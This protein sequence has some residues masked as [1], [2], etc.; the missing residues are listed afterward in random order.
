ML[1]LRL[2]QA[3]Y[4]PLLFVTCIIGIGAV[5]VYVFKQPV[6]EDVN[7]N[8]TKQA[9]D[10][11][12]TT[13]ESTVSAAEEKDQINK[14]VLKKVVASATPS[15]KPVVSLSP[16]VSPT[17]SFTSSFATITL[18][19]RADSESPNASGKVVVELYDIGSA[20]DPRAKLASFRIQGNVSGLKAN[21]AYWIGVYGT[22]GG[23]VGFLKFT[24]DASGNASVK[25]PSNGSYS[26]NST[27]FTPDNPLSYVGVFD[28][29]VGEVLRPVLKGD[30]VIANNTITAK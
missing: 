8:I 14:P 3:K 11:T 1:Y 29:K 5:L 28:D 15:P 27:G 17:S 30:F 23:G 18:L 12:I 21:T 7:R 19:P 2:M 6:A 10:T 13:K 20:P 9:A 4:K 22:N 25:I 16:T 26:G 24:T